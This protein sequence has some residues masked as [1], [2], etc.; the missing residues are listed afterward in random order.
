MW[1]LYPTKNQ[2]GQTKIST[3]HKKSVK[4]LRLNEGVFTLSSEP[5]IVILAACLLAKTWR[6]NHTVT[7][8][9]RKINKIP[10]AIRRVGISPVEKEIINFL[11]NKVYE[12]CEPWIAVVGEIKIQ[13]SAVFHA[14]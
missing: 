4:T 13:V 3:Q 1:L 11:T 6:R 5:L 12:Q 7:G 8:S 2:E 10:Q 14:D 9:W